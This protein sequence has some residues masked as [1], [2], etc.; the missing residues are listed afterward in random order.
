MCSCSVVCPIDGKRT[1]YVVLNV[2]CIVLP[3][4]QMVSHRNTANLAAELI[5]QGEVRHQA[6]TKFSRDWVMWVFMRD[7]NKPCCRCWS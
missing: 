1:T 7:M 6:V 5:R 4:C 3:H 2:L